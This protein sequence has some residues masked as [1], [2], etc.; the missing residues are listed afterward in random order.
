MTPVTQKLDKWRIAAGVVLAGVSAIPTLVLLEIVGQLIAAGFPGARSHM[1]LFLD[2][3]MLSSGSPLLGRVLLACTSL[4]S[5]VVYVALYCIV[6][7]VPLLLLARRLHLRSSLIFA[8]VAALPAAGIDL[9]IHKPTLHGALLIGSLT[10]VACLV[11]H[12]TATRRGIGGCESRH[13]EL[14]GTPLSRIKL[15]VVFAAGMLLG[16]V[17][18]FVGIF[19]WLHQADKVIN[20]RLDKRRAMASSRPTLDPPRIDTSGEHAV[21]PGDW[22]LRSVSGEKVE[23]SSFEGKVVLVNLWATWCGPCLA[24]IPSI[25]KLAETTPKDS[26]S[27]VLIAKDSPRALREFLAKKPGLPI[28]VYQIDGEAP[29]MLRS[30]VVPVT[31]ILDR[32]GRVVLHHTGAADWSSRP[33]RDLIRQLN[34]GKTPGT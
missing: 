27:V 10:A 3:P 7:G 30:S 4:G 11:L 21:M 28:P 13:S 26:L 9:L 5:H 34:S 31:F 12:L 29:D 25:V 32:K 1:H 18:T 17:L 2:S 24:E 8:L 23:F 6:I 22:P 15:I 33:V 14:G 20:A 19:A 16:V